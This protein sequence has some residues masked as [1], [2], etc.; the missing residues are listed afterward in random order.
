MWDLDGERI[1]DLEKNL[2]F[3]NPWINDCAMRGKSTM[4]AIH[5]PM[6]SNW[7]FRKSA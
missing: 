6:P 5:E 7:A 3:G 1:I 4:D 2:A